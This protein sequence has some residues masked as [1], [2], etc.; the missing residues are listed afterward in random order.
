MASSGSGEPLYRVL[1]LLEKVKK[2]G[3]GYEA[4]CPGP[5]HKHED[6]H[7][8]L[9]VALGYDG[10]VLLHCQAGCEITEILD[11]LRLTWTDLFERTSAGN[12]VRRFRLLNGTG[13]VVAEHVREDIPGDKIIR[14]EHQGHNGLNGVKTEDLPL[15]RMPDLLT[16]QTDPVIVCE[17][18]KAAEAL[19][20]LGLLAVGTVT[21]A[22][23]TPSKGALS[24]LQGREVWLWPDNDQIGREHME[25]ISKL[26]QPSPKWIEWPDAPDKGDAADYAAQGGVAAGVTALVTTRAVKLVPQRSGPKIWTASELSDARFIAPRWAIPGLLPA[27]LAILAGRPKLGKSWLGL[28]WAIDLARGTLVFRKMEVVAGEVL[29]LALEDGPQRMQERIALM[30]G[31]CPAPPRLHIATEWPRMNEGGLDL[32]DQWLDAHPTARMVVVDTFKRV[33]PQEKGNARLYDMDY[34]AIQPVAELARHRN[35]AIV[36]VFHTRKGVSEDPLEMVSGTLGLSGAADAVLVLR[37]ERGQADASLFVT[38]RDV[39][40]QDLALR[41]EKDD[42]LGWVLLGPADQFRKSKERQ[43]IVDAITAMP[44]MSPAEIADAIG[45]NRGAVRYLLFAMV[46]DNEVRVRDGK[47]A[48]TTN[49]NSPNSN[50]NSMVPPLTGGL[51]TN[52]VSDSA[53]REVRA[54]RGPDTYGRCLKCARGFEVHGPQD[55][56]QCEWKQR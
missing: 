49:A 20:E 27:G 19:A 46:R 40:E 26:I 24:V 5:R 12:P 22:G 30:L 50:L 37:R 4:S 3:S 54:V 18:E 56:I 47:Y 23:S 42:E 36:V 39:E 45:K 10:R 55:P 11:A 35:V 31:D 15:Y 33:R 43:E 48:P 32:L 7:P 44:G 16:N 8:S 1:G 51:T 52:P 25:R 9:G 29:Y 38:G 2:S 6:K 17:G 53:M 21:G 34:D 13:Q 14:W 28:G 41:W